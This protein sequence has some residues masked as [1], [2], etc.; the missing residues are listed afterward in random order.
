V[1]KY[2]VR[3]KIIIND[4]ALEQA[5]Y[6]KFHGH[7]LSIDFDDNVKSKL[8]RLRNICG[9]IRRTLRD[10]IR[11]DTQQ[12]FYKTVVVPS[13][14]YGRITWIFRTKSYKNLQPSEMKCL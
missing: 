13:L 11:N 2:S 9:T 7:D 14:L 12:R 5:S 4:K 10:E 8:H 1:C 6:F 3:I